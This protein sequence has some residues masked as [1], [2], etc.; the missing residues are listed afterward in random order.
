MAAAIFAVVNAFIRPVAQLCSPSPHHRDPRAVRPGRQRPDVPA[1]RLAGL[2]RAFDLGLRVDGF[3]AAFLG[4]LVMA[5]IS[6]VL[7]RVL[8][9]P[10]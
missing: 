8:P 3:W 6:W 4:A 7:G 2:G 1:G 5:F 9:E 10:K